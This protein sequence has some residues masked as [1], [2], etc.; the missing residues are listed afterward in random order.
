MRKAVG[1]RWAVVAAGAMLLVIAAA[2]AAEKEIVEVEKQVV[3]EK[4]VVKE[5]PVEKIVEKEVVTEVPV[6]RV[7]VKEVPVEKIVKEVVEKV[8]IQ[9][10]EVP[11]EKVV[12]VEK[13]VPKVVTEEKVVIEERVVVK[14]I[15]KEIVLQPTVVDLAPERKNPRGQ[16][17]WAARAVNDIYGGFPSVVI[18]VPT[19][20]FSV[21]ETLFMPG[22]TGPAEPMVAEDWTFSDDMGSV[23]VDIRQGIPFHRDFG[24]LTAEDVAWS[25]ND[26]IPKFTPESVADGGGS[27][28]AMIDVPLEVVDTYKVKITFATF[29]PRWDTWFFGQ[30][31][32]SATPVSKNAFDTKGRDWN[33]DNVIGT[34][35]FQL[36]E[37]VRGDRYVFEAL[38]SHWRKTA[39]VQLV[40]VQAVPDEAVR[41]AVIETGE[42]DVT[43]V[44]TA[45]IPGLV[46]KG[47]AIGNRNVGRQYSIHWSGNLW[48]THHLRTGELLDVQT[49]CS[50]PHI[51]CP[52]LGDEHMERARKV[53]FALAISIDR[54][55]INE[56][57]VAGLG[58]RNDLGFFP[59]DN[60]NWNDKWL[61]QYDPEMAEKL[62]D[63]AG[64]PRAIETVRGEKRAAGIRM[65]LPLVGRNPGSADAKVADAVV[66][67]W[68]DIGIDVDYRKLLYQVFRPR[69]VDKTFTSPWIGGGPPATRSNTPWDWPRGPQWTSLGRGGKSAVNEIPKVGEL[70]EKALSEFDRA[71]RIK[72]NNELAD[73][74]HFWALQTGVVSIPTLIVY[75]PR[76]IAEWKMP[77]GV[78]RPS[79]CVENIVLPKD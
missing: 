15:I 13:E 64:Y 3:V 76:S 44:A 19:K 57:V 10:V 77:K 16:L 78:S 17:V 26:A 38:P 43:E 79:C 58:V 40:R 37:W 56:A 22:D 41:Q 48:E 5:V 73:Y 33:L 55:L 63:E 60:P 59:V 4:E 2:C 71:E 36:K 52:S 14:E 21:T 46:E 53:R 67:F 11:V 72:L 7:V 8:V 30:D 20:S 35:P 28:N 24:E 18:G 62:L 34:G 42:A 54:D 12:V 23:V 74:M 68:A 6:E 31:G 45:L 61:Y 65:T 1:L 69:L 50:L 25:F 51:G 70:L 49:D 66:G 47:V 27:W 9:R 29:D 75:N 32:L 39:E